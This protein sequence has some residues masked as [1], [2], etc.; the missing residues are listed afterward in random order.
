MP[1]THINK[2]KLKKMGTVELSMSI[3][4]EIVLKVESWR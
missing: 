4:G 1:S 2:K 3:E